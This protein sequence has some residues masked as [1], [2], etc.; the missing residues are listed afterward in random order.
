M[1][2]LYIKNIKITDIY[3]IFDLDNDS[4]SSKIINSETISAHLH[5]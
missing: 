4:D 3:F 2:Q 1:R 5:F